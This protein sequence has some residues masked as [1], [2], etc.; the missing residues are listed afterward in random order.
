MGVIFKNADIGDIPQIM[1]IEN[2]CFPP[3]EA[4]TV[5][6]VSARIAAAPELFIVALDEDSGRIMGFINGISTNEA[7][8][9]DEFFT[10]TSLHDPDGC[11]VMVISL[12]VL[13]SCRNAGL[14]HMLIDKLLAR[15]RLYGKRQVA[16][17][18][19]EALIKKYER[20][21]FKLRGIS[22]SRWGGGS[23][24]EMFGEVFK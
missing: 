24:F 12:E 14:G 19:H 10:D 7:S 13:P 23:W 5:Q 1:Q 22:D 18:C 9:R 4:E 8:F 16:F 15:A 17:I 2:E 20:M 11:N 3:N 6:A 21:G